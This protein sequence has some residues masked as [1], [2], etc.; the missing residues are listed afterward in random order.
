MGELSAV[1]TVWDAKIP[2]A[3]GSSGIGFEISVCRDNDLEC[4]ESIS[5]TDHFFSVS[6]WRGISNL[7]RMKL[8][9]NPPRAITTNLNSLYDTCISNNFKTPIV[10]LG[11]LKGIF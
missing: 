1:E 5:E 7:K 2:T 10:E 3:T 8:E 11:C 9:A 6:L 4:L